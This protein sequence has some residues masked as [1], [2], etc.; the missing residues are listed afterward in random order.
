M[1]WPGLADQSPLGFPIPLDHSRSLSY[2]SPPV[3]PLT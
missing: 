3:L 2:S 1:S